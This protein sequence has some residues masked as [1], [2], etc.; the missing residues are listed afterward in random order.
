MKG[1]SYL[2]LGEIRNR[3]KAQ[4][5]EYYELLS[6]NKKARIEHTL[7]LFEEVETL[8]KLTKELQG[9]KN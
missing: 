3:R 9:G 8:N 5:K 7:K 4:N 1:D 2:S 6:R